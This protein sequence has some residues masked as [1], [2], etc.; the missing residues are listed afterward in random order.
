MGFNWVF[1]GLS[2]KTCNYL[3]SCTKVLTNFT[4]WRLNYATGYPHHAPRFDV[5]ALKHP[6]KNRIFS[7]KITKIE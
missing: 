6:E 4:Y 3:Y 5:I 2:N 1:K 7:L